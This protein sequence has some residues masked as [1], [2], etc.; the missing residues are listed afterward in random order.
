MLDNASGNSPGTDSGTRGKGARGDDSF[1]VVIGFPSDDGSDGVRDDRGLVNVGLESN[2]DPDS[3]GDDSFSIDFGNVFCDGHDDPFDDHDDEHRL[4]FTATSEDFGELDVD[5]SPWAP[6]LGVLDSTEPEEWPGDRPF[7]PG[8]GVEEAHAL[9]LRA[10]SM[11]LYCERG[12]ERTGKLDRTEVG[13]SDDNRD[14]V[15]GRDEVEIDGMLDEHTGHGL[16]HVADDVEVNVGGRLRIHAHLED[17]IIM[18]GVMRDE[19]AGGTFITA[20]MSDDMAAGLGLRCTAPLDVWVH[21]LVGME[22]RP[23]TCAADGI[24]FELAGTLYEREYGPSAH[25]ALVARHSGTVVTTMKTG[26][27]PLMKVALGVRNLIPGGGGGGGDASASPP[28]APPAPGGGETAG[29]ATL[30]A[31]ESGGALGRGAAG[32][33]DTEEIVSVARTA[34]SAS[35]TTEIENLQHPAS[36]ADNVDNLARIEVDGTGYQQVAEIYEQPVPASAV[37]EPDGGGSV[38][39]RLD[40]FDGSQTGEGALVEP[41]RVEGDPDLDAW[42]DGG[43]DGDE[44]AHHSVVGGEHRVDPD[45]SDPGGASASATDAQT[46]LS[47]RRPP[48][49]STPTSNPELPN[50][51]F[52]TPRPEA[53]D[54]TEPGTEGFDFGKSYDSLRNRKHHYREHTNWRGNMALRE[55]IDAVDKKA[56]DLFEGLDGSL[57]DVLDDATT[58]TVAIR[59]EL[60]RMAVVAE[61]TGDA[62]RLADIR[63]A[64]DELDEFVHGAV[65]DMAAR[66]DEFSGAALGSQRVPIDRHIDTDMLRSWFQEQLAKADDKLMAA[67]DLADADAGAVPGLQ[68]GW[69]KLYYDQMIRSLDK[70]VNPLTDSNELVIHVREKVR[71]YY[72]SY[73]ID[74]DEFATSDWGILVPRSKDEDQLDLL[75]ELHGLLVTTLS[76]PE[77]IR[78]VDDVG[79]STFTSHAHRRIQWELDILEPDS[80][81]RSADS[82]P[83]PPLPAPSRSSTAGDLD[84]ARN[85]YFSRSTLSASEDTLERRV[86]DFSEQDAGGPSRSSSSGVGSGFDSTPA[87]SPGNHRAP[88]DNA[89]APVIDE[90]SGLWVVEPPAGTD[91]TP[92]TSDSASPPAHREGTSS[93]ASPVSWESGLRE[94]DDSEVGAA[95]S[96]ADDA[97]TSDLFKAPSEPNDENAGEAQ[98]ATAASDGSSGSPAAGSDGT[99]DAGANPTGT[100]SEAT[101]SITTTSG[102]GT[103]TEPGSSGISPGTPDPVSTGSHAFDAPAPY[104]GFDP[105]S[106]ASVAPGWARDDFEVERALNEGRLPPEFDASGLGGQWTRSVTDS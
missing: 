96:G 40:T 92:T 28:A 13:V 77:Y 94:S 24:L 87:T 67:Q 78:G 101:D 65:I 97:E 104:L 95:A 37:S 100:V 33:G 34:E 56:L 61:A 14:I 8:E 51:V 99:G 91:T 43:S 17:N 20:A 74:I 102:I 98:H 31:V 62:Q 39:S 35:Q 46:P 90:Q 6:L 83:L 80:L 86:L 48:E 26:F 5:L 30:T 105:G 53:L 55:A 52:E 3:T 32:G 57:D 71:G 72:L 60:E 79:A 73:G 58:P 22:E 59:N 41:H 103:G 106:D 45:I 42:V 9:E 10:E 64:I 85:Q 21:G 66:A 88:P 68:A 18:A 27:R 25:V 49:D 70:G 81:R 63:T 2:D 75:L 15:A 1:T 11:L 84:T 44:V 69:E 16:V 47:S 93:Q 7:T 12:A 50:A 19:F 89:Q 54:L 4:G 76:D 29:A 38:H 23:G 82:E 36:T